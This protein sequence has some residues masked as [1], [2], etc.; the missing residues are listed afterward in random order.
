MI[1]SQSQIEAAASL[2]SIFKCPMMPEGLWQR[3][4]R[5]WF[6]EPARFFAGGGLTPDGIPFGFIMKA[7]LNLENKATRR[8][9]IEKASAHLA[10]CRPQGFAASTF[11]QV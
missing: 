1:H 2:M 11:F 10:H 4:A 5:I 8:L 3:Y 9:Y 7:A 6:C